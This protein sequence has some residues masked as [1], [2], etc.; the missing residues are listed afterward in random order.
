MVTPKETLKYLPLT[1]ATFYI[2][3][4]LVDPMHGYAVMQWI[5]EVSEN[6]VKVGPGTLYGVFSTLEKENLIEKVKDEERRKYFT[7]TEKG[8]AVLAEQLRRLEI[9]SSLGKAALN[10][11]KDNDKEER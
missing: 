5:E 6:T 8:R 2:M 11:E 9:M 10:G 1:E 4:A 3:V 7:L